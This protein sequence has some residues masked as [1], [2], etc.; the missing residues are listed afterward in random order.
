[1]IL[2]EI[3]AHKQKELA[4]GL[5]KMREEPLLSAAR[6]APAPRD[7]GG[8]LRHGSDVAVIAEIKKASPSA[9]VLCEQLDVASRARAYQRAG[10]GAISIVTDSR[11]FRGEPE[12]VGQVKSASELPVLRKD[13]IIDPLQVLESRAIGAD[14][15]LLITAILTDDRLAELLGLVHQWKMAALVEVHNEKELERAVCAGASIIGINNRDLKTFHVDLGITNRLVKL[16]PYGVTI[17]SESG[18]H[19][20]G[21][22]QCVAE[23]GVDAILVGTSLM[24]REEPGPLLNTLT[25]VP[26]CSRCG[27]SA[28]AATA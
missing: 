16:I 6:T 24:R 15:V 27:G 5:A 17:V 12:W 26:K 13:F 20:R 22:V 3:V 8:A 2:D 11:F 28:Q 4:D 25:G 14:A 1:M 9:G 18:V 23:A 7:F 19:S 21:D 10:V